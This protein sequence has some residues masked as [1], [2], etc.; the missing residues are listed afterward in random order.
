[1]ISVDMTDL[2]LSSHELWKGRP[3]V[4]QVLRRDGGAVL[5]IHDHRLRRTGLIGDVRAWFEEHRI[6][7]HAML[8][9]DTLFLKNR[10]YLKARD[11]RVLV[12]VDDV[13]TSVLMLPP[14]G[15]LIHISAQ[16]M[17]DFTGYCGGY[18]S[19]RGWLWSDLGRLKHLSDMTLGSIR[20]TDAVTG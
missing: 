8:I 20:F 18:L 10:S 15:R 6:R 5:A 4:A 3:T 11:L 12:S 13:G 14:S 7:R 17:E 16:D 1:M 2:A 9:L 19:P